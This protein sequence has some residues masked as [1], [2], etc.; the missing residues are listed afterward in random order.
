MVGYRD[1]RYFAAKS[2]SVPGR[3]ASDT[4]KTDWH[5]KQDG[6]ARNLD[7]RTASAATN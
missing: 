4:P 6:Q 3:D 5:A 7:G 2:N 1:E